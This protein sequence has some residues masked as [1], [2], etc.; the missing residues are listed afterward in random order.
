[1]KVHSLLSSA[2]ALTS[3]RARIV[4]VSGIAMMAGACASG[5]VAGTST[6]A[7]S[8][9]GASATMS[10]NATSSARNDELV[11]RDVEVTGTRF[12]KRVCKPASEW[13]DLGRRQSADAR[14]FIRQ[15]VENGTLV[16][17]SDGS[18]GGAGAQLY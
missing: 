10:L 16:Q 7:D 4:L 3:L 15:T 9:S 14:E 6:S 1:M 12:P 2:S 5:P 8:G 11:C 17:G 13:S 18:S